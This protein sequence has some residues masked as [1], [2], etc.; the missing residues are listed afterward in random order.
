MNSRR[1]LDCG[2]PIDACF[3]SVLA[4]DILLVEMKLIPPTAV[5][6]RCGKCAEICIRDDNFSS[7]AHPL[8]VPTC[9]LP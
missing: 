1:C 8:L 9:V 3:G 2:V 6:E 5:R 7:P 4:G